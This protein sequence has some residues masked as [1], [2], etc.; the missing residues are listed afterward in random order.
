M[1]EIDDQ[2]ITMKGRLMQFEKKDPVVA[3][4]HRPIVTSIR[5]QLGGRSTAGE[6]A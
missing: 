4:A 6:G 1:F 3:R 5:S 2:H